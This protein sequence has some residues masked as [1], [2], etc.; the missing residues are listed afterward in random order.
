M[1]NSSGEIEKLIDSL[2][3]QVVVNMTMQACSEA[4][5]DLTVYYKVSLPFLT[6]ILFWS[7]INLFRLP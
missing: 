2:Q 1:S 3:Q 6:A 4:Q 7:N 5:N